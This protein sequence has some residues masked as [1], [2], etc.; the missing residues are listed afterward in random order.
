[1]IG[2]GVQGFRYR[3]TTERGCV[4]ALTLIPGTARDQ[5]R[6]QEALREACTLVVEGLTAAAAIADLSV[7]DR[8]F[9]LRARGRY[10]RIGRI[11]TSLL[12]GV[13]EGGA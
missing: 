10:A 11:D 5:E 4:M 8:A 1:M 6:E 3:D 7:E 2:T 13:D 9:L 12:V